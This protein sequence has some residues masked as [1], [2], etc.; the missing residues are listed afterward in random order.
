L[1]SSTG[2]AQSIKN[3]KIKFFIDTTITIMKSKAVNADKVNWTTIK[4]TA[5]QKASSLDDP[6]KMGDVL[7]FIFSSINDSHGAFFYRDSTF[8]WQNKKIEFSDSIRNE[9]KKG[10]TV[11][12][13]MLDS[14]VGYLSIPSMSAGNKK[15]SDANAQNLNDHLSALLDKGVKG[16]V[17]DLRT[18]GGGAM[19]PMI[20]GL[21]QLLKPGIVGSFTGKKEQNWYVKDNKF[22]TDTVL[23]TIVPKSKINAQA[24]PIVMLISPITGSSAEFLIIAF[25]GR[26]NTILLGS[27]TAG[28]VTS[29]EG[30]KV[31]EAYMY[32]SVG[33]GKDSNGKLYKE[34]IEPDIPFKAVDNF[35]NLKADEKV[36]AAMKW[37][38]QQIK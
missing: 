23:S 16:I 38:N 6:N 5:Y 12:S 34:A 11:K 20:L 9:W 17:I 25:K 29:V 15:E 27:K 28:A 18:N 14:K 21:Q 31:D 13:Q 2:F 33:Y 3:A 24:M 22:Y 1:Q 37:I 35:N 7:R 19:F 32:L 8:K 30:M 10:Y 36:Q 4:N 26:E